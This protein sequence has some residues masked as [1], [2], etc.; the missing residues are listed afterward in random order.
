MRLHDYGLSFGLEVRKNNWKLA[1]FDFHELLDLNFI[2]LFLN[3]EAYLALSVHGVT[4]FNIDLYYQ[5]Q[6]PGMLL[7]FEIYDPQFSGVKERYFQIPLQDFI[8]HD[9]YE[10]ATLKDF[11]V[12]IVENELI[13]KGRCERIMQ[14]LASSSRIV[15]KYV[16]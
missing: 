9:E 11:L 12:F 15:D 16:A 3:E 5:N 10:T 6:A 4:I 7:D 13:D 1:I 2:N 8:T 14:A